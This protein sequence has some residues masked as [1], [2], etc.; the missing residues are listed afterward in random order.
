MQ[1]GPRAK[2]WIDMTHLYSKNK[3]TG[4]LLGPKVSSLGAHKKFVAGNILA[5]NSQRPLSP[6][7]VHFKWTP[8]SIKNDFSRLSG[9]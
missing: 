8:V 4:L 1:R 3:E 6:L 7:Q 5:A 2:Y 9:A